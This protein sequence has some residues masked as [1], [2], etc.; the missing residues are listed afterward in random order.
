MGRNTGLPIR[1]QSRPK[2]RGSSTSSSSRTTSADILEKLGRPGIGQ[3]L[4]HLVAPGL[5]LSSCRVRSSARAAAHR[6]GPRPR[7]AARKVPVSG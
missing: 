3:R 6:A 5:V 2:P 4:G 1:R 7:R